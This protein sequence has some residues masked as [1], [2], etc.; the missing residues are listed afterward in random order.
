M[1]VVEK[2]EAGSLRD[3]IIYDKICRIEDPTLVKKFMG[4]GET[5]IQAVY[6][7]VVQYLTYINS[8]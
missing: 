6:E 8:K 2:I 1:P 7:A 3:V 5:K 4:A